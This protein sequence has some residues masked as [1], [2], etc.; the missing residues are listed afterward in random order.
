MRLD[1]ALVERG[2]APSRSR[3]QELIKLG[4]VSISGQTA[5]KASVRVDPQADFSISDDAHDYVSRAALKL[6]G[7][8]DAFP[9]DPAGKVA[10]D[11]GSSTGGFT[12]VLL[13]H[14]AAKVY[15]VD[16]GRDQL[17][18]SLRNRPEVV[19]LEGTHAKDLTR[20]LIQEPIDILVCDVSFISILKAL[21]PVAA[22]MRKGGDMITLTKPQFELGKDAIGKNGRVLPS[23]EE[24]EGFIRE[25]ILPEIASW[26]FTIHELINSPILGGEGTK[27]FLLHATKT[28]D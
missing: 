10:L 1:Q 12:E 9:V 7:A 19:S 4:H 6:A 27:E 13:R 2:L 23:P 22:L 25:T 11:L 20:E 28:T 26:G 24:Q 8:L 21:P 17:H 3:A 18:P 16:V 15:S 14:G 5:T